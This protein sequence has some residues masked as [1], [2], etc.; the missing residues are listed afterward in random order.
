M[1]T[2]MLPLVP[3]L[4]LLRLLFAAARRVIGLALT[5]IFRPLDL[6]L[7]LPGV[8]ALRSRFM[9]EQDL[10]E[11]LERRAKR[12]APENLLVNDRRREYAEST[13]DPKL[14]P[15]LY[16][17]VPPELERSIVAD[18]RV[19][20]GMAP[21][22]A[23][24]PS[25]VTPELVTAAYRRAVV[26]GLHSAW[27]VILIGAA[28]SVLVVWS[29]ARLQLLPVPEQAQVI[30]RSRAVDV[31]VWND[32]ELAQARAQINSSQARRQSIVN[33]GQSVARFVG[34]VGT[35]A[36]LVSALITFAVGVG[37][38]VWVARFRG[39]VRAAVEHTASGLRSG[40]R[41]A[42]QRHRY[43]L[44]SRELEASAHARA[45]SYV[46]A[47]DRSPMLQLGTAQ[48]VFEFRGALGAPRQGQVMQM[49][50]LDLSQHVV[51][52][53]ASGEGKSRDVAR[54][55]LR[56]L[57]A[58]RAQGYP[59]GLYCTDGKGVLWRDVEEE[60][61]RAGCEHDLRIVGT[62]AGQWRVDLLDG[63]P[64]TVV[65]DI[66]KSVARQ[67]GGPAADDFWPDMASGLLL[68]TGVLCQAWE[69]TS[70]GTRWVRDNGYRAFSLRNMLRVASSDEALSGMIGDVLAALKDSMQYP[71]IAQFD[72]PA[73]YSAIE[74]QID[75]WLPMAEATKSGILANARKALRLFAFEPT[76]SSGFADGAGPNL[77]PV[78]E[79]FGKHLIAT[80]IS[81]I[82][83]GAAGRL[84]AVML[85]TLLF[86][87]AR[88]AEAKAPGLGD[89]RL[90][91]WS[92]PDLRQAVDPRFAFTVFVADEYQDLVT[93]DPASGLSDATFW[94]V[95][96]SS[97]ICGF[98][99]TQGLAA[100]RLAIG[101]DA[102]ANMTGQLRSKIVLR[103]EDLDTID[104]ARKLAG[105]ATR[106]V[107]VA[108]EHSE[109]SVA[110]RREWGARSDPDNVERSDFSAVASM[111]WHL[112]MTV[113]AFA[114]RGF[115]EMYSTDL[116][117]I[118]SGKMSG[119]ERLSAEQAAHWRREDLERA[120]LTQGASNE[121]V[122]S[123]ADVLQMG[124]G[125][126]VMFMQR[127]GITRC[128]I[129]E[130]NTYTQQG[131]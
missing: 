68:E 56:Q 124:R 3:V 88:L 87:E 21:A 31:D 17:D 1:K 86:R 29:M 41:E 121:D 55:V 27:L 14:H 16:C 22:T 4:A 113:G 106:Y 36:L 37:G 38:L 33:A 126:A 117:F 35:L 65:A 39:L 92:N 125:R 40:W 9:P 84:V 63:V 18:G 131:Q 67:L 97:G 48:G 42:L 2:F 61:R 47:R 102:V 76:L 77:L 74:G 64:P 107:T 130:L 60:A 46:N 127:G 43:R 82:E 99:M 23:L 44:E 89:R 8:V 5:V 15:T 12:A 58:L 50:L 83:F 6:A 123:E 100:L 116:R 109:S 34:G 30:E 115:D 10:L 108:S 49:S 52:L 71:R 118:P 111:P 66:I 62:A 11:W 104:Y 53:G 69:L 72:G 24:A 95:A 93:S 59:V 114:V 7:R 70:A 129:V 91:F 75:G 32:T 26:D 85:K 112:S 54:P 13:A 110:A 101:T 25:S 78:S 19:V 81:Q 119:M 80:N 90:D 122:L 128:D 120:A 51:V 28:I 105:K 73:L 94:N 45:V 103:L 96:R 57:L 20:N 79:L 98:L